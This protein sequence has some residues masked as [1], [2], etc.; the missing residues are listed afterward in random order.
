MVV[1]RLLRRLGEVLVDD[2]KRRRC[3]QRGAQWIRRILLV[4]VLGYAGFLL[5]LPTVFRSIGEHNLSVAF[6][7]YVPRVIALFPLVL[8]FPLA[9]L[10]NWRLSPIILVAGAMFLRT[11]MDWRSS[12][13]PT[14]AAAGSDPVLTVL[15]YNRGQ[16]MNQSLQPFKQ[17]TQPDLL[18]LQESP[19]RAAG[20]AKAEGYEEFTSTA[21]CGEFTLLSRFP[22]LTSELIEIPDG[23]RV[24]APAAR[25]EIDYLGS[26]IALYSIHTIS[27]RDTLGYYRRGPFLYGILGL[28]GTSWG[29]KR[30]INQQFWDNRIAQAKELARI[31]EADPLP[32][33]V[34]GDF[35]APAGGHIHGLFLDHLKDA[36]REAGSGFGFT[37]PGVTRNPLSR[38]GPWMRIDY[39]FCDDHW[40]TKWCVTEADRPSQHRA[41]AAQ[42]RL[43]APKP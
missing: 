9:L 20:Y 23:G 15:T 5:L 41:V 33:I 16:H 8:L 39:L 4:I 22:I 35:N 24:V 19:N 25:F 6:G 26:R 40:E 3:L 37:F 18:A 1:D 7:L 11:G 30:K 31:I 14:R 10:V 32:T 42:F 27:P 2:E 43:V 36:H 21:D 13:S 29:E 17:A 38:G 28:P 34:V 12:S